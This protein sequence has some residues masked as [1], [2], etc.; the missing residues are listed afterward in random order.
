M[1]ARPRRRRR[2]LPGVLLGVVVALVGGTAVAWRLDLLDP[3]LDELGA[4]SSASPSPS[5]TPSTLPPEVLGIVLPSPAA[6]SPVASAA[7][8]TRV[9]RPVRVGAALV[10]GLADPALGRHTVVR[11]EALGG[12]PS[13]SS[14]D[15]PVVPASTTKLLTT[16]AALATLGPDHVFTTRVVAGQSRRDVVLVG[17]GD[18][19]LMSKPLEPGEEAAVYPHRADVVDLARQTAASL[20]AEGVRRVRVGYDDGLFSGPAFSSGWKRSYRTDEVVAP[21]TALWVDEGRP[22]SGFGRVADPSGRAAAVFARALARQGVTVLGPPVAAA[23]TPKARELAHVDS[24]PLSQVVERIL[25][26]SDNEAAEVLGHHVGLATGGE[27]SFED[28][29]A[30][31]ERTLR[32]LGVPLTDATLFDGSGLSRLDRLDPATL[33]A[34]LRLAADPDHPELRPVLTGLPVAGFTG[35]LSYRFEDEARG[36]AGVVRAKTGTLT[37][38]SGLAG[39]VTDRSGTPLVFVVVADRIAVRDTLDARAALDRIATSLARC[40]CSGPAR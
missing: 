31:V 17:G 2:W 10:T 6:P 27:G 9:L 40:R 13:Y 33:V 32:G 12:G 20:R 18:P 16:T 8:E 26:V 34:V 7:D 25:D 1:A 14:G 5:A 3:V 35:S 24:A 38:V 22:A 37:G 11:V 36:G 39:V 19:Y 29:V 28:G 21:I 4:G 15:T 23:A 30:G